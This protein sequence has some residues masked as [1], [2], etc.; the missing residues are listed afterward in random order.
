MKSILSEDR[1][2]WGPIAVPVAS[3]RIDAAQTRRW[4]N[5]V[6]YGDY[7]DDAST[8]LGAIMQAI[9]SQADA[10]HLDRIVEL[11]GRNCYRSMGKGRGHDAYIDNILEE[12]HGSVTEFATVV[13]GVAGVSRSLTHE[14]VR[15]RAGTAFAQESQRY[16]DMS[17]ARVVVPAALA[18]IADNNPD[19]KQIVTLRREMA[20]RF[21]EYEQW[22]EVFAAQFTA[23]ARAKFGVDVISELPPAVKRIVRKRANEA[24]REFLPNSVE[25]RLFFGANIR[26]IRHVVEMRG[27]AHADLQ[28]RRLAQ[29]ILLETQRIAPALLGDI[30]LA[31]TDDFFD[32]PE[33]KV[34]HSKI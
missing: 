22:Q 13:F 16:V 4:A 21:T 3:T 5:L 25:T 34:V 29:A 10:S 33:V 1:L 8:P 28:I 26:S 23:M 14:L 19:N 31:K 12:R 30:R 24:A 32:M 17:Q 2:V 20:D 6:G 15:H 27:S 11:A 18:L 7:L 9:E